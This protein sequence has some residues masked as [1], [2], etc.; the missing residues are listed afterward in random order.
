MK[1]YLIRNYRNIEF[2][3]KTRRKRFELD[4]NYTRQY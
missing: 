4:F 3:K 1:C 2:K